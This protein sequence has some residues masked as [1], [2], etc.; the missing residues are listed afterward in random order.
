MAALNCQKPKDPNYHNW[1]GKRATKGAYFQGVLEMRSKI[2][3]RQKGF[4][5]NLQ[6]EKGRMKEW[7]AENSYPN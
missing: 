7:E 2:D 6:P 1:Q 5:K 4:Y 3:G